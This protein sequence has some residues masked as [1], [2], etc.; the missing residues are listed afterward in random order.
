METGH[1]AFLNLV[2]D[3]ERETCSQWNISK[4]LLYLVGGRDDGCSFSALS[5]FLSLICG[6]GARVSVER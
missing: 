5:L 4:V 6:T 1:L 3:V 2:W